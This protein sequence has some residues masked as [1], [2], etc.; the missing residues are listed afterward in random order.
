M[1][2]SKANTCNLNCNGNIVPPQFSSLIDIAVTKIMEENS[3]PVKNAENISN[4]ILS[5]LD[6]ADFCTAVFN[7]ED[8]TQSLPS[9]IR[10]LDRAMV[11]QFEEFCEQLLQRLNDKKVNYI[12]KKY[13]FNIIPRG[14]CLDLFL[15]L[16]KDY[17][18]GANEVHNFEVK[19]EKLTKDHTVNGKI[20]WLHIYNSDEYKACMNSLF[21]LIFSRIKQ[22]ATPIPALNFQMDKKYSP[23]RIN[24]FLNSIHNLWQ[25]ELSIPQAS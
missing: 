24:S 3:L 5:H 16:I 6:A 1:K 18:L 19:I 13:F 20:C 2:C 15:G 12:K 11:Q 9:K 25:A 23:K 10:I 21:L 7:E 4:K 14:E 8:K 17:Y 22:G